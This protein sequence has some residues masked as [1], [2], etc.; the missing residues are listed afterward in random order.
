MSVL[1]EQFEQIQDYEPARRP[2]PRIVLLL[3]LVTPEGGENNFSAIF[4]AAFRR[5]TD[6]VKKS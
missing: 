5:L 4:S 2:F 6:L 1:F 3:E